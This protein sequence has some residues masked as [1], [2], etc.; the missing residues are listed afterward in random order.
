MYNPQDMM[1]NFAQRYLGDATGNLLFPM[2]C[3]FSWK[4]NEAIWRKL[5][6]VLHVLQDQS[7]YNRRYNVQYATVADYM[8]VVNQSPDEND[9]NFITTK[10]EFLPYNDGDQA[11]WTG[12]YSSYPTLKRE[13][14]KAETLLHSCNQ[15]YTLYGAGNTSFYSALEHLRRAVS[16]VTH[17]DGITGTS[18]KYVVYDYYITELQQ[19]SKECLIHMGHALSRSTKHTASFTD[20][21]SKTGITPVIVYNN[22]AWERTG[23]VSLEIPNDE[24]FCVYD[25]NGNKVPSQ[26]QKITSQTVDWNGVVTKTTTDTLLFTPSDVQALGYKT[27]FASIC[28]PEQNVQVKTSNF[29]IGNSRVGLKFCKGIVGLMPCAYTKNGVETPIEIEYLAY[30][31][32]RGGWG[33]GEQGSGA[34]I[35]N[36]MNFVP[37]TNFANQDKPHNFV[38]NATLHDGP[39]QIVEQ[40]ISPYLRHEFKICKDDDSIRYTITA[41]GAKIPRG[42]E[43]VTRMYT[44]IKNDRTI[45]CDKNGLETRKYDYRSDVSIPTSQVAASFLPM[46][47]SCFIRDSSN[48]Q[49]TILTS[50]AQAASSQIEGSIEVMVYR[51]AQED[52]GRG[53]GETL[54]DNTEYSFTMMLYLEN[55]SYEYKEDSFVYPSETLE[56][57]YPLLTAVSTPVPVKEQYAGESSFGA[58]LSLD[59]VHLLSLDTVA[60]RN[61][62]DFD[63]TV[64]RLHNVHTSEKVVS[65]ESFLKEY[66]LELVEETTLASSRSIGEPTQHIS[67]RPNQIRTFIAVKSSQL[68]AYNAA[69]LAIQNDKPTKPPTT[70]AAPTTKAP[71]TTT[72]AA[73]TTTQAPSTTPFPTILFQMAQNGSLWFFTVILGLV[74][75][76]VIAVLFLI[77]SQYLIDSGAL[78]DM[79]SRQN[80]RLSHSATASW[81]EDLSDD[82]PR[83]NFR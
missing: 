70:T 18:K 4:P 76:V 57:N 78:K 66:D 56:H 22:L 31:G 19:S 14:R 16:E 61:G 40:T 52:D 67:L 46:V 27:Y 21:V 13:A 15:I 39:C 55:K 50:Q 64:V 72:T 63:H 75:V 24:S 48:L 51:V 41:G 8:K 12:Y 10:D 49:F 17:H 68:E 26:T 77:N 23:L 54:D 44:P 35:F 65:I 53:L 79:F 20:K 58:K 34:Y 81:D 3:D 30:H 1:R 33:S 2:G 42:L 62:R 82:E 5:D 37:S 45:Y 74:T 11:W 60:D 69:Q 25:T 36:P 28:N 83:H 7:K 38:A 32:V 71:T 47:Q 80:R 6:P 73:P 59:N 43:I 29:T 9:K